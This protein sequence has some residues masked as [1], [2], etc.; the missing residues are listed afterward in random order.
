MTM[1]PI[2]Q[3]AINGESIVKL[4]EEFYGPRGPLAEAGWEMRESQREMSLRFAAQ[5][6]DATTEDEDDDSGSIGLIEAPTGTGKGGAYLVPGFLAAL[7]AEAIYRGSEPN[8]K[9]HPAKLIISTAN[10]ALQSQL[11]RKDIPAMGRMLGVEPRTTLMK[12]RQNYVCRE[13]LVQ[14]AGSMYGRQDPTIQDVYRWTQRPGCD[15]DRESYPGDTSEVWHKV[16]RGSEDCGR[17]SCPHFDME[18][19]M[20]PCF[21]RAATHDWPRSHIIV[22][23][24]HWVALSKGIKVLAYAVDEAHELENALRSVQG[25]TLATSN[26][27]TA[28]KRGAK[29]L[30][31]DGDAVERAITDIAQFLFERIE[32]YIGD[33]IGDVSETDPKYRSP[34]PL[35]DGWAD[36]DLLARLGKAFAILRQ[37]R[38]KVVDMALAMNFNSLFDG[39]VQTRTNEKTEEA[40]ESRKGAMAANRVIELCKAMGAT[41]LGRPHPDWPSIQSP[42]AI[43]AHRE[44]D[45]KKQWRVVV[46]L[47]PADVAPSFAGV[48]A[49][50]KTLLL[51]SATLPEFSS[52]RLSL[53]LG[54]RWTGQP[55]K[56]WPSM[57]A[58]NTGRFS[59]GF[60]IN[61]PPEHDEPRDDEPTS[62]RMATPSTLA[63][64]P[65]FERRL[66]SPYPLE[67]MG[68]IIVPGGPPPGDTAAW[69][70][71]ATRKVVA[72]VKHSGG[73]ALILA[74]SNAAMRRYTDAL[75]A[76][77]RWTVLKQG[78]AG[79]SQVIQAF[80]D[81]EDSVLVGTRSM[82]QGLDVQGRS[83][84]LVV[85]DRIPFASPEDPLENAV[86]KLLVERAE[87]LNPNVA[88]ANPWMVRAIPEA[89][90]VLVQ[91]VG[92]LIRSQED[93][94]AVVLLDNRILNPGTGWSILRN[95]LPPFPLSYDLGDIAKV[96]RSEPLRGVS[97]SQSS[98]VQADLAF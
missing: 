91:G 19:G 9:N 20:A 87:A 79:R 94:G 40:K 1:H 51:A 22:G 86:G 5:I 47:V 34:I 12:S 24:H 82:F 65:I 70:D 77:N 17:Q 23:N 69:P 39:E 15:G 98:S 43:W 36:G 44:Q 78:D 90:M 95:A 89:A 80:K 63:P 21:W 88:G 42:W 28:A 4:V 55:N 72:A 50:Y 29:L 11:V 56:P 64:E 54:G 81:D 18:G 26:F 16:S 32:R 67:S 57:F 48:Y 45:A 49:K 37:F 60:Q 27:V 46:D 85:I 6:D 92:R 83:C 52:M 93:R 68:V 62:N 76:E 25:R 31:A 71:W 74:T 73:G 8:A 58:T 75:R 53:G 97:R 66:P 13:E 61:A 59:N 30:D 14:A 96:L 3:R 7:R 38:D 84:R 2:A 35:K 33:R 10:I 41:C